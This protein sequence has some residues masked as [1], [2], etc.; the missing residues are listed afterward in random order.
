MAIFRRISCFVIACI[1]S[2]CSTISPAY[3][4]VASFAGLPAI[5]AII[6][7]TVGTFTEFGGG[8]NITRSA[9][10][11]A[12][13]ASIPFTIAETATAAEVAAGGVAAALASP[14]GI[15]AGI[16]IGAAILYGWH[17]CT[18]SPS[19]WCK[20]VPTDIKLNGWAGCG[21]TYTSQAAAIECRK[22]SQ[23]LGSAFIAVPASQPDYLTPCQGT[24]QCLDVTH[25]FNIARASNANDIV[26]YGVPVYHFSNIP[27][28]T[29]ATDVIQETD[30]IH[31]PEA[32]P[33]LERAFNE[34]KQRPVDLANAAQADGHP[35]DDPD[36]NPQ[37]PTTVP[38]PKVDLAPTTK[39]D[40]ATDGTTTK[41]DCAQSAM[42]GVSAGGNAVAY[43]TASKTVDCTA[44]TTAP[45][46][47]TKTTTT[48]TTT[49]PKTAPDTSGPKECGTPG[50]PKC[51]IDETGT[52]TSIGTALDAPKAAVDK[53]T[54]DAT[55]QIQTQVNTPRDTSW[56]FSFALPSGCVPLTLW[57][58]V[59][60][61]Y[62]RF[63]PVI[64]DLM[65][66]LWYGSTFFVIIG[67]FGRAARNA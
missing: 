50:R 53:S 22:Q 23:G 65:S 26:S 11:L 10:A 49:E 46:G 1:I 3:A 61:D 38:T 48:S 42:L 14:I 15:A 37:L 67:M 64:H 32:Q 17:V 31:S 58:G 30:P 35:I 56:K 21:E 55:T 5:N 20:T 62:C 59:T 6:R 54:T 25:Y 18:Q 9:F 13:G 4:T 47:T 51:Q 28:G 52:P 57:D 16:V 66:M 24:Y 2:F 36:V 34:N 33:L 12:E 40:T 8:V 45:D 41:T 19:G 27:G 29:A 43:L 44:V 7:G 39:T 60:A 63:Q